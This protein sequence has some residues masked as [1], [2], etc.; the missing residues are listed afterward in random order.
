MRRKRG[1]IVRR[2]FDRNARQILK[3]S[4]KTM[5]GKIVYTLNNGDIARVRLTP[6]G[7]LVISWL[8]GGMMYSSGSAVLETTSND[9]AQYRRLYTSECAEKG[10]D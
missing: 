3:Y 9:R 1:E 2:L 8:P 7:H 10:W 4:L 6:G 5:D